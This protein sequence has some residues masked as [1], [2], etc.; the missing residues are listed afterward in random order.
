MCLPP[1]YGLK[2]NQQM[3]SIKGAVNK[4]GSIDVSVN[5]R[6]TGI[7][8]DHIHDML[9]VLSKDKVQKQLN[10]HLDLSTYDIKD[11]KYKETLQNVP[12]VNE[13]LDIY[14]SDYA[15]MSGETFIYV[16]KFFEQKQFAY[17]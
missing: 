11:F 7:Q 8:Q 4:D 9:T 2:E 16:A 17:A 15:T 6:Y 13:E 3:R 14:L 12:V 10:E 1:K 5:T